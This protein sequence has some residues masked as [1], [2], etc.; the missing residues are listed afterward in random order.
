MNQ[1]PL[2]SADY[3]LTSKRTRKRVFLDEM[4]TVVPW[5]ALETLIAPHYP[6]G[7]A[8]RPVTGISTMLRV[9]FMQQWFGLSDPAMEEALHDVAIYRQFITQPDGSLTIPDETTIL[10]FRHLLER[11]QIAP[12]ILA[13]VNTLLAMKGLLLKQG[14]AIDATLIA[15]PVSTKNKQGERDPE[16]HSS[17]KGN[18]W[19]FGMKAH[20]GVDTASGLVHTVTASSGNAHDITEAQN[21]L[22]GQEIHVVADAGYQGLGEREAFTSKHPQLKPEQLLTSM[23]RGKRKQLDKS[24]ELGKLIDQAEKLI[25]QVRAKVEHPFRVIKR[26]FGYVK[27]RYR[28]LAKNAAQQTTLFALSNLW[29]VRA[30]LMKS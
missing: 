26:Q 8:G 5:A 2:A 7:T 11:H 23:R 25:S 15:A 16:M 17:Q 19:H 3:E 4:N 30:K 27:V 20:I 18:Q 1:L 6:K 14:T 22:H 28:G 10:R 13:A 24:S 29:M 21:L 9:H 12:K